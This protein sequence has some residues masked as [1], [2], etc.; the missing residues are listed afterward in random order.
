M[1]CIALLEVQDLG[2]ET[3]VLVSDY[4]KKTGWTMSNRFT[5]CRVF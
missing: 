1:N 5:Y 2:E 4:L 3:V